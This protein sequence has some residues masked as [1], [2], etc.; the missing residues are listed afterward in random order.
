MLFQRLWVKGS[1]VKDF[2]KLMDE[3]QRDKRVKVLRLPYMVSS[4]EMPI[5]LPDHDEP[6]FCASI[7][8][9]EGHDDYFARRILLDRIVDSTGFFPLDDE[10]CSSFSFYFPKDVKGAIR[11]KYFTE[12]AISK[13]GTVTD[14]KLRQSSCFKNDLGLLVGNDKEYGDTVHLLDAYKKALDLI[15]ALWEAVVDAPEIPV[16]NII[17]DLESA[18]DPIDAPRLETLLAN[19][20]CLNDFIDSLG[21]S[22]YAGA[23]GRTQKIEQYVRFVRQVLAILIA[24]LRNR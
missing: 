19:V 11:E 24:E 21:N 7:V 1:K 2:K 18:C 3:L 14:G 22:P 17:D 12:D 8:L 23:Y 20:S 10:H 13:I 9:F 4:E 5:D 15:A 6:V 16:F